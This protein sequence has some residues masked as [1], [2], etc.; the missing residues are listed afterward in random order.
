[1]AANFN[2]SFMLNL[3]CL[4]SKHTYSYIY[5]LLIQNKN[6]L[7]HW[8]FFCKTNLAEII[9]AYLWE[10]HSNSFFTLWQIVLAYYFTPCKLLSVCVYAFICIW[11]W[12][13]MSMKNFA[14][15]LPQSKLLRYF[16]ISVVC[17]A[18]F[19]TYTTFDT[20]CS[21]MVKQQAAQQFV[22]TTNTNKVRNNSNNNSNGGSSSIST[23]IF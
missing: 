16:P 5:K 9:L 4:T 17:M 21:N 6:L 3:S 1:M 8:K 23:S 19:L 20:V 7:V 13:K 14:K 22:S 2:L 12:G 10:S 18:K 15:K 11:A